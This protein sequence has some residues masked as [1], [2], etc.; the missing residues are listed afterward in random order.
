MSVV[1]TLRY[2]CPPDEWITLNGLKTFL[3]D[4]FRV[5][6]GADAVPRVTIQNS[7]GPSKVG[8]IQHVV[9]EDVLD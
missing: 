1:R 2:G 6:F 5:G 3:D 4:A 7:E 9:I 8:T